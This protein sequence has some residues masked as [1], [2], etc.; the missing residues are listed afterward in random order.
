MLLFLEGKQ[1]LTGCFHSSFLTWTSWLLNM[2]V[3]PKVTMHLQTKKKRSENFSFLILCCIVVVEVPLLVNPAFLFLG[4]NS[5]PALFFVKFMQISTDIIQSS[6]F[7]SSFQFKRGQ[8]GDFK[9]TAEEDN[10]S[11]C[12][13]QLRNCILG[14]FFWL[15]CRLGGIF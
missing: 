9:M 12:S 7:H 3:L 8:L 1:N 13:W 10:L 5:L 2:H 6:L 14:A 15:L 11:Y 4:E